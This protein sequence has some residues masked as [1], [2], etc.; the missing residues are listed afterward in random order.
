MLNSVVISSYAWVSPLG[1]EELVFDQ[2]LYGAHCA[3]SARAVDLPGQDVFFVPVS[4]CDLD[5]TK[6]TSQSKIPL[7]RG[8]AF[9]LSAAGQALIKAGFAKI[10]DSSD[11][12]NIDISGVDADR[13]GVFWGC[14][15]G[16]AHSFDQSAIQIYEHS[17]RPRPTTVIT[18][19][20]NSAAAELA[21][22]I[23]AQGA[24]M[25]Y[26]CACASSSIAMGEAM[27][28]LRA[29]WLDVA[30]VGGSESMLSPGVL[31]SWNALR[32]LA[33]VSQTDTSRT[34]RPFSKDRNGFAMGE[35][36]AAFVLERREHALQRGRESKLFLSGFASNC[37]ATHMTHPDPAGQKKVM[38][39]ALKDAGLTPADIGYINAHATA[40]AAGDT[41]EATSV[42]SV[43]GNQTPISSTKAQ[44]G[45]MLGAAGA[46]EMVVSLRALENNKLP[47]NANL[48]PENT[49]FDLNFV[50]APASTDQ[51]MKDKNEGKEPVS[52]TTDASQNHAPLRH[53]MSNSFAFGGTNAVLIASLIK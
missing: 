4:E 38:Q 44:F 11:A 35:G 42:L 39:A 50:F 22:L 23:K 29:G 46:L 28:A 45:H 9:A 33:P 47:P 12:I 20:P 43:F 19:M 10:E 30:L 13:V 36:A 51:S 1:H 7:D 24:S 40:T 41:A 8:V 3:I 27:R 53:V 49:E 48:K 21:L 31:A 16:G 6:V 17:K 5:V 52:F 2:N 37:D 25:T 15:M 26:S 14:G 18:T 32:V 34:C